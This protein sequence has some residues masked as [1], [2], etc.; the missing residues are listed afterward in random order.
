MAGICKA[1]LVEPPIAISTVIAFLKALAVIMS[2]GRISFANKSIMRLPACLAKAILAP[3]LAKIVPLPGRPMPSTSVMQFMVLAVNMPAQEPQPGQAQCS[4]SLN[5][6]LL[7]LPASKRP[8]ASNT[9]L[10]L[11]SLPS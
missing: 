10:T 3:V 9:V 8:A 6:F 4:I 2:R 11:T 1:V 7:I 5:C